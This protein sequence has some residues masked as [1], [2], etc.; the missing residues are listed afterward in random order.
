M[1]NHGS[2][3]ASRRFMCDERLFE[4]SILEDYL[5][6]CQGPGTV[7]CTFKYPLQLKPHASAIV[8]KVVARASS[9]RV[10]VVGLA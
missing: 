6:F 1:N 3:L 9:R 7:I 5:D 2:E 4:T 10:T 8:G